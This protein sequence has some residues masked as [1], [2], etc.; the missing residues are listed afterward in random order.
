MNSSFRL[1]GRMRKLVEKKNMT[2]CVV[3]LGT[4]GLVLATFLAEA[5]FSVTGLDIDQSRVEQVNSGDVPFEFRRVLLGVIRRRRLHATSKPPEAISSADMIFVCVPTPLKVD[6]TIDKTNIHSAAKTIG[7]NIR[8]G[9][10]VVVESTVSI[11]MTR[12]VGSMIAERSGLKMGPEFGLACCPERY[13]P[14]LSKES[15]PLIAYKTSNIQETRQTF[16]AVGR[17]V[18]GID[19]F[20]ASV[21]R[22]VYEQFIDAEIKVLSSIEAAE[23]TKIVENIFRD[24][25]IALANEF[26]K[27][28]PDLGLN[29]YEVIDGAKTKPFAF[30]P[31]YPGAGVGG[32]CIP[33]VPWFLIN[34]AENAGLS[35]GIM[36]TAREVNDSMP[37][38]VVHLLAEE[39]GRLGRKIESSNVTLLGLSYKK[40]IND[41]RHSPTWRIKE[42]LE[43]QGATVR[44]CDPI[45]AKFA[46]P[47]ELLPLSKAFTGVDAAVLVTDHDLFQNL[48][49]RKI[50]LEMRT[51]VIIDGRHLFDSDKLLKLG[52]AYRCIGVPRQR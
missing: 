12:E 5:G 3:G 20:S 21:V 41:I 8:H 4:I 23:A 9:A 11:G 45:V 35:A 32:E 38:Y 46:K 13:N 10:I 22:L 24:V 28:L 34:Q 17:V 1:V 47:F 50:K 14:T 44:V 36:K 18:G 43:T 49:F 52:F 16:D 33:V 31:H 27:I 30:L 29:V 39:F 26:A 2:M 37:S 6:N 7:E 19:E 15:H 40:N 25:N 42:V 48:N 51:P